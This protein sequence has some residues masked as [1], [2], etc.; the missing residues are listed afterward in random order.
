MSAQR[1]KEDS[2]EVV[3]CEYCGLKTRKDNLKRHTDTQHPGSNVKWKRIVSQKSRLTDFY[4][5]APQTNPVPLID[6]G[7]KQFEVVD[8]DANSNE[9]PTVD[10]SLEVSKDI[11]IEL[12]TFVDTHGNQL[13]V[14]IAPAEKVESYKIQQI[15]KVG[16]ETL[17][18]VDEIKKILENMTIVNS[19]AKDVT[20]TD[21]NNNFIES[22]IEDFKEK[23][24]SC[25]NVSAVEEFL[26]QKGFNVYQEEGS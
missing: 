11:D 17:E 6:P 20:I 2:K 18:K 24:N 4:T 13:D 10:D 21:N 7:P 3:M 14:D 16:V 9:N 15:K 8:F 5:K 1:G 26:V 19:K 25:T 12:D 22:Q 23:L